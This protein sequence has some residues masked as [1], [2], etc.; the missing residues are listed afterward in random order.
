MFV[1]DFM[2]EDFFET[3]VLLI[4]FVMLGRYLENSAKGRTSAAITKLLSLQ[5]KTAVVLTPVEGSENEFAEEEIDVDLVERG[6]LLKVV[7]G[8]VIPTDGLV[9]RGASSVN[10]S[11]ITGES[12]PVTKRVGSKVIGGTHRKHTKFKQN[13]QK[14]K[15]QFPKIRKNLVPTADY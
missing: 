1:E 10:E 8:A 13:Y 7:P 9:V 2:A 14:R 5:S 6:D 12:M 15:F 4:C 11:M 3:A